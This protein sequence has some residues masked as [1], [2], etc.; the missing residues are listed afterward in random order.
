MSPFEIF[1]LSV[2]GTTTVLIVHYF[3]GLSLAPH[4]IHAT[5]DDALNHMSAHYARYGNGPLDFGEDPYTTPRRIGV[6]CTLS[7]ESLRLPGKPVIKIPNHLTYRIVLNGLYRL[8][9]WLLMDAHYASVFVQIKDEG[10]TGSDMPAG[11]LWMKP[12]T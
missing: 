3:P 1:S 10:L 11:Y 2:P 9:E 4:A 5:L 7:L 8:A 12:F 6:N